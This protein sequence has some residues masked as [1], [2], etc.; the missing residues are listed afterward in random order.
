MSEEMTSP[1]GG[2]EGAAVAT[3]GVSDSGQSASTGTIG[4]G[5]SPESQGGIAATTE[6]AEATGNSVLESEVSVANPTSEFDIES[7]DGNIDL[8]PSEWQE[9]VR[10]IHRNLESGYT[11]KFQTLSDERKQFETDR[12]LWSSEKGEWEKSRKDIETERDMLKR[13]LEGEDDPRIQEYADAR[14][15]FKTDLDKIQ[16]EYNEYKQFVDADIEQQAKAFASQFREQ[17]A[18][19][20]DSEEKRQE[21][22]GLL[23]EGWEPEIAVQLVGQNDQ[24]VSLAKDLANS[25]TPQKVAVEHSLLKAGNAPRTPRP[26]ARITSGSTSRNNPAST[27]STGIPA[28]NRDARMTAARAAV[29]WAKEQKL[30]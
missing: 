25:G 17:H 14:D 6:T 24:V 23:T 9:P 28:S 18:K 8:L 16:S 5:E 4:E 7:W 15:S 10:H 1:S 11:K 29:N 26:G 3:S 12:D 2:G 30:S 20:F 22:S 19:I 21:L 13:V 27:Q